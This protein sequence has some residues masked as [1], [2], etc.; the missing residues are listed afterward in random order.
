[1]KF[2][3]KIYTTTHS[4]TLH[5]ASDCVCLN[6]LK[7]FKILYI[8][9]LWEELLFSLFVVGFVAVIVILFVCFVEHYINWRLSYLCFCVSWV[10]F[11]F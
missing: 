11:N 10:H 2:Y 1:M 7:T 6:C 3:T 9:L 5:I 4:S 8:C